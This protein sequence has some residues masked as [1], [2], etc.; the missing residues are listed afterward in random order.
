MQNEGLKNPPS[1]EGIYDQNRIDVNDPAELDYWT[2]RLHCSAD[3]LK[4]AVAKV[5]TFYGRVADYLQ[6]KTLSD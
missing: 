5:G 3:D 4:E 6:D 2:K 1:N